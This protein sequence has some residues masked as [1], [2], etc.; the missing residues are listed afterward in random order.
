MIVLTN[1]EDFPEKQLHSFVKKLKKNHEL[2]STAID[3]DCDFL[4]LQLGR[5]NSHAFTLHLKSCTTSWSTK[6]SWFA[7]ICPR[8]K[9]HPTHAS[10]PM[11]SRKSPPMDVARKNYSGVPGS[12]L[13]VSFTKPEL[14]HALQLLSQFDASSTDAAV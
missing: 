14:L 6:F 5:Q 12:V 1:V 3:D 13:Y 8:P 4:G 9:P 10:R 7:Q 11:F 2:I